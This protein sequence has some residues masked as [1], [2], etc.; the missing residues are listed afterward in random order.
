MVL[1]IRS[2]KRFQIFFFVSMARFVTRERIGIFA[3]HDFCSPS[4]S[5]F[6]LN[7]VAI[8]INNY[9]LCLHP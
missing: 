7:L 5:T 3:V 2:R 6:V 1:C 8:S 4:L 9:Q